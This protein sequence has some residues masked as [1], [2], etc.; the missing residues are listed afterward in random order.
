MLLLRLALEQRFEEGSE[1]DDAE[2]TISVTARKG[3][4]FGATD[5]MNSAQAC[6]CRLSTINHLN[7]LRSPPAASQDMI[8]GMFRMIRIQL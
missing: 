7:L 8:S 4:G 6:V 1:E 2:S 5:G 3:D